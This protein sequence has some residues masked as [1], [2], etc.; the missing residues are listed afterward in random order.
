MR[1][2]RPEGGRRTRGGGGARP[3]EGSGTETDG[4][5]DSGYAEQQVDVTR[6]WRACIK[7]SKPIGKLTKHLFYILD[8]LRASP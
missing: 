4:R 8:P 5:T 7:A 3:G 1:G 2:D 6:C